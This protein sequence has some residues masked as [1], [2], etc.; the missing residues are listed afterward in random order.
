MRPLIPFQ[1]LVK[2]ILN[3]EILEKLQEHRLFQEIMI[4]EIIPLQFYIIMLR[5]SA[6]IM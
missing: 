2:T 1:R 5:Y 3:S 4:Y 6:I